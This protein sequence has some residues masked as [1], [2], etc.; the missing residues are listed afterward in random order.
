MGA[1][2]C[3]RVAGRRALVD[4]LDGWRLRSQE[5][6]ATIPAVDSIAV[7]LRIATISLRRKA[8]IWAMGAEDL[9]PHLFRIPI[10]ANL[11]KSC[12]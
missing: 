7:K 4:H 5:P 6:A 8:D 12:F 3:R 9:P 11:T 2:E 10:H 1:D